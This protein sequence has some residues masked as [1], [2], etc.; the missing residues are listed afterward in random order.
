M[1]C[2]CTHI[3]SALLDTKLQAHVIVTLMRDSFY[4]V[5]ITNFKQL[6]QELDSSAQPAEFQVHEILE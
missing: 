4:L 2:V 3:A 1:P 5:N 6:E